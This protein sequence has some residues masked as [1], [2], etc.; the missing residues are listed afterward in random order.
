MPR[1]NSPR[2]DPRDTQI[3]S[4]LAERGRLLEQIQHLRKDMLGILPHPFPRLL[5]D[6]QGNETVEKI[7]ATVKAA[8]TTVVQTDPVVR[9][10][11]SRVYCPLCRSEG[12]NTASQ[13]KGLSFPEGLRRHLCGENNA[14]QCC[15]MEAAQDLAEARAIRKGE[16]AP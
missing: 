12:N 5:R 10:D 9:H 7:L 4:L 8:P 1:R 14:R 3:E 15:V 6:W 11:R 2:F 16:G 13:T